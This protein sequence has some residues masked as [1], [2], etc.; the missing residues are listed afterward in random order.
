MCVCVCVCA[1][2]RAVPYMCAEA[3]GKPKRS[4]FLKRV[5]V[6]ACA[7]THTHTR[8][9]MYACKR[10]CISER[11][12]KGEKEMGGRGVGGIM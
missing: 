5:C 8:M 9:C 10:L 2:L 3:H 1:C 7:R 4:S 11:D 6:C 12:S